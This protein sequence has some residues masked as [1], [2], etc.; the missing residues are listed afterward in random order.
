MLPSLLAGKEH[1]EEFQQAWAKAS[2]G[3]AAAIP[4]MAD[5]KEKISLLDQSAE[6]LGARIFSALKPAIDGVITSFTNW[7][8]AVKSDDIRGAVDTVGNTSITVAQDIALFFINA[9]EAWDLF[10]SSIQK[11]MPLIH[12]AAGAALAVL[13]QGG[14]AIEQFKEALAGVGQGQSFEAIEAGAN[15]S[16]EAINQMADDMRKALAAGSPKAGSGAAMAADFA[17]IQQGVQGVIAAY[18]KLNAVPINEGAGAGVKAAQA[19]I[20]GEI[21]VLQEG[22]KQKT[23][24]YDSEAS[25]Y[26][27][28]QNQKYG[29]LQTATQQEYDAEMALL[30]K[31]AVS[32]TSR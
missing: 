15:K 11:D 6:S 12:A 28:T 16:R 24:L 19:E 25:Q 21:E 1:I 29:L 8:Q 27:I 23:T 20:N 7:A 22:L 31:E 3:L 17:A 4:G 10:V 14:A 32:A 2:D 13:G 18:Q 9:K 30:Q 26:Q 5:T